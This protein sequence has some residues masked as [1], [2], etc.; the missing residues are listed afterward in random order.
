MKEE[1][2][3]QKQLENI[4]IKEWEENFDRE[5][6]IRE[7]KE[8]LRE[9][10]L[11]EKELEKSKSFEAEKSIDKKYSSSLLDFNIDKTKEN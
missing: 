8:N 6:K 5:Q 3:R 10:M 1:E 2:D 4:R 11:R 9:Q 7:H